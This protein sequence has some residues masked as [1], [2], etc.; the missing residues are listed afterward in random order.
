MSVI[1]NYKIIFY[2]QL[3]S[4]DSINQHD[5]PLIYGLSAFKIKSL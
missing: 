3:T 5:P 2:N 4:I 1:F